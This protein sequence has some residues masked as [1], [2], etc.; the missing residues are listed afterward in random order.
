MASANK[1]HKKQKPP[2]SRPIST[3]AISQPPPIDNESSSLASLSAFS[4]DGKWFA[5]L[6]LAIDKHRLRVFDTQKGYGSKVV[7]EYVLQVSSVTSLRWG[8]IKHGDANSHQDAQEWKKSKSKKRKKTKDEESVAIPST[9]VIVLGLANGSVTCFS[10]THGTTI[11]S[12]SDS[13]STSPILDAIIDEDERHLWT[14]SGDGFVRLWDTQETQSAPIVY[15]SRADDDRTPYSTLALCPQ[16][17]AGDSR[18]ILAAHHNISLIELGMEEASLG[19]T[20]KSRKFQTKARF[21]GHASTI[22]S[23]KWIPSEDTSL[24]A[25]VTTAERDRF[26]QGWKMP[27]ISPFSAAEG[28][29]L[30]SASVD[31]TVRKV[32]FSPDGTLLLVISST[33]NISVFSDVSSATGGQPLE[34]KSIISVAIVAGKM[35]EPVKVLDA[36]FISGEGS[37]QLACIVEGARPVFHS[38]VRVI[39]A[40]EDGRLLVQPSNSQIAMVNYSHE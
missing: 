21:T 13:A 1:S 40:L 14:S 38:T 5:L 35:S 37:I 9:Q 25:F 23:I 22:S 10:P 3:S 30:F 36:I 12:L 18:R 2:K 39:F 31:G 6:S 19:D 20:S 4:P 8:K 34:A 7:A 28:A 29:I 26:V 15:S 32:Q 24:Q 17:E 11:I 27:S 33:G 16:Q